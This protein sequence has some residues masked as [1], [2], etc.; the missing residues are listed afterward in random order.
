VVPSQTN[1]VMVDIRRPVR[2]FREA[3]R[4][5]GVAVGRPFPPLD[6]FARISMG[7]M[8]EMQRAAVVFREVLG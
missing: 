5:K 6:T 1:F 3:C 2:A 4:A 7:T 8:E